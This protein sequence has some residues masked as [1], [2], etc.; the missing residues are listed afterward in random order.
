MDNVR[1]TGN[2]QEKGK[3]EEG[4]Q[5][6]EEDKM[7]TRRDKGSLK[8]RKEELHSESINRNRKRDRPREKDNGSVE[9]RGEKTRDGEG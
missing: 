3:T 9:V 2:K 4:K 8:G 7:G 6:T 1:N 5:G